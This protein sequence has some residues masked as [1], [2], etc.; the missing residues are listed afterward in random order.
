MSHSTHVRVSILDSEY[1]VILGNRALAEHHGIASREKKSWN[2]QE[3]LREIRALDR[4]VNAFDMSIINLLLWDLERKD[5]LYE[6]V[7]RECGGTYTRYNNLWLTITH[8]D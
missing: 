3:A 7:E 2:E 1:H 4:W 5:D 6:W 8:L